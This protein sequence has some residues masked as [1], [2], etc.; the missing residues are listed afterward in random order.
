MSVVAADSE[1]AWDRRRL[2]VILVSAGLTAALLAVGLGYAM[3][4]AVTS[5]VTAAATGNAAG[6]AV[7]AIPLDTPVRGQ[8]H[9]DTVSAAT[10]I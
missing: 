1:G 2:L 6:P 4:S 3:Y 9:R 5:T 8:A 7:G 10:P